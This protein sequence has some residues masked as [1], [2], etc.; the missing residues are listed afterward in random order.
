MGEIIKSYFI[1]SPMQYSSTDIDAV[2]TGG[3]WILDVMFKDKKYHY[4]SFST[5]RLLLE[6]GQP[7]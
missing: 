4:C 7:T 6:F 2:N 5:G 1:I 3:L